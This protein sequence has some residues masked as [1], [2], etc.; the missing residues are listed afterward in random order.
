[1]DLNRGVPPEDSQRWDGARWVTIVPIT[2]PLSYRSCE[3]S[4]ML[5]DEDGQTDAPLMPLCYLSDNFMRGDFYSKLS[6]ATV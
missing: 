2:V 4:E 6:Y 1:M 3:F 5:A